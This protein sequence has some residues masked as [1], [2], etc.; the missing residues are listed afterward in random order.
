M[1]IDR[2]SPKPALDRAFLGS[3]DGSASLKIYI[4]ESKKGALPLPKRLKERPIR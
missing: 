4:P 2:L 3:K 1:S